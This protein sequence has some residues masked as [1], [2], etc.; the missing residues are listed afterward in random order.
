M[1]V[2]RRTCDVCRVMADPS[3]SSMY[4]ADHVTD[5]GRSPG[6]SQAFP[7]GIYE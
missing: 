2:V 6:V 7:V 3:I 4:D 5:N 1:S